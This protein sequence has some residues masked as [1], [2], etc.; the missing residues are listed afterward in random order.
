MQLNGH[1][2]KVTDAAGSFQF[3]SPPEPGTPF[4]VVAAGWALAVVEL[5]SGTDNVVTLSPPSSNALYLTEDN[6]PPKKVYRVVAAPLGGDFIPSGVLE[7]LAE[8]NGMNSFQLLG[9]GR[10]GAVVLPEFLAP[11]TYQFFIS[12]RPPKGQTRPLYDRIGTLTLPGP[13]AAVLR[14]GSKQPAR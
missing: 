11:G 10:D 7:D 1:F 6:A 4:Y 13:K 2:Q 12:H 5:Q 14:V 8:A 9:N 3:D